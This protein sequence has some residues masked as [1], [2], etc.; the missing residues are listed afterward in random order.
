MPQPATDFRDEGDCIRFYVEAD[1]D[2]FQNKGGTNQTVSYLTGAFN[3]VH[4]L[5][6]NENLS[7]TISEMFVW[8]NPSPY[9]GNSSSGFLNQF[10]DTRPSF[11]GDLAILLN[12]ANTGGVAY[13]NGLCSFNQI[14][15]MGYAGINT[16]YNNL[17][18]Y[19]WTVDVIAHELG[20]LFGSQHTHACV[21]NGN[22]TAIDGCY[23]TEGGCANPGYPTKGTIMS[24]CHLSGR[25][26][27]DF[28][29]GFGPQPGNVIRN[30]VAAASCLGTSCSGG[31]GANCNDGVQNGDETGVDCGGS[32]SPCATCNDGVQNGSETG[33]DCGGP[34]CGPCN[35]GDCTEVTV[36]IRLDNYGSETT[37][38]IIDA[39]GNT[40]LSGGP[41]A[42]NTNGNI[43]T[44]TQCL[45]QGC[46]DFSINDSYGD[47]ICCAYGNG[48]YELKDANGTVLASGGNFNS[49]ET[50]N[51][52]VGGDAPSCTDGVQNGNETGVDCGG[53]DCSPCAT[54]NDGV[55][56]GSE[57]GVD[58]GGPDCS[59]CATCNDGVQNGD[60][61]GVD[62][63]G[64]CSPCATCNDGVQNGSETGVDCGGPDCGPCATCNDGVQNGDET[65]VDCGGSCSPCDTG[66]GE[67]TDVNL[68]LI[69]DNYGS[70][71]TW[72]IRDAGGNTVAS[73]G[74]YSNGTNGQAITDSWCLDAGCYDFIINDAY[75]DGIC[76]AY[77]SGS[78][79]L[80]DNDG[81]ELASGGAFNSA[82]SKNFCVGDSDPVP[83]CDDG[84]Q[85]GSETGVDC[86][87]PD[88][89]PCN[90]GGGECFTDENDFENG[91]G[92]WIDGGSD[93]ALVNTA[94]SNS[95]TVAV[96]LRDNTSSSVVTTEA[97]DF[98]GATAVRVEFTYMA[99]SMDNANEDFWLQVSTN[100]GVDFT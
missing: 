76:C 90:T 56:N 29:L 48:S 42:N 66:G 47:G 25:P 52:C 22:S 71:T 31:A 28:T 44:A 9:S 54:C 33:V 87:G 4:T 36:R 3:Q 59:P 45:P 61:T 98:S 21:W 94:Y 96:R 18:N 72:A 95:G 69:L 17:P 49:T 83:T 1:Y 5:Y 75:G 46:Y 57:T 27:K 40:L 81:N 13:V 78:Y 32:C 16:S 93:C 97:L 62:C 43:V 51:F 35:T 53:P 86:G 15:S 60:E 37:W 89:A 100:G 7:T 6:A 10:Q 82:D 55:Q 84:I 77:G 70:E 64:S 65:G 19:S 67:C 80:A 39:G 34:D 73:G 11:N 63:G 88:C 91:L 74:P 92:M 20:H 58:C 12:L 38:S 26:G 85:N 79:L 24:Y 14:Y 30:R 2:L 41:Y 8:S 68:T 23:T 99:V 50:K